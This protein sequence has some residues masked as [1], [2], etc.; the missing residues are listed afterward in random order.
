MG[1]FQLAQ[2]RKAH[3]NVVW[4]LLGK[5]LLKRGDGQMGRMMECLVS[6]R[7]EKGFDL[8]VRSEMP[9]LLTGPTGTGKTSLAAAIHL[10]SARATRPFVSVNLATLSEGTFESELFGHE[11]GAFTGA[12]Q[13]RQGKLELAQGGTLFL[14]EVGELPPRL[15]ARLLEVLHSKTLSPVGSNRKISLN[16]RI[17]SATCRNLNNKAAFREDL[18][19]RLRGIPIQIPSLAELSDELDGV[20]HLLLERICREQGRT[21]LRLAPEV[22]ER[23]ERHPW[24]GNLRELRNVLEYAVLQSSGDTLRSQDLPEDVGNL[25]LEG[26]QEACPE[27]GVAEFALPLDYHLALASF[28]REFLRRALERHRGRVNRTA[29]SIGLSKTTLIRRIRAYGFIFQ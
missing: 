24:P 21:L 3:L 7:L 25:S 2:A 12:D 14:D 27:L 29:A 5:A 16:A 8:A 10:A 20:V 11:R 15:Q 9:V 28:E 26:V 22:A 4:P 18:L 1:R 23:L 13:R 17:I 19:H 6:R